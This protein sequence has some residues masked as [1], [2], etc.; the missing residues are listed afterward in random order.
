MIAAV[1]EGVQ[2][3]VVAPGRD[4][5]DEQRVVH[6][7]RRMAV[8][9]FSRCQWKPGARRAAAEIS[10]KIATNLR[11]AG[12]SSG[13]RI[14]DTVAW[15]GTCPARSASIGASCISRALV[16]MRSPQTV[17]VVTHTLSRPLRGADV[18]S[19]HQPPDERHA[20][21]TRIYDEHAVRVFAYAR[22]HAGPD[23]ARDVVSDV[24]LVAWRRLDAVPAEPLPW[25]LVVAR[26]TIANLRRARRRHA[27]ADGDVIDTLDRLASSHG[28]DETV[29]DRAELLAALAALTELEREALLLVAW[30]GLSNREA[31]TVAGCSARAFEVRLSRARARLERELDAPATISFER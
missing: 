30:D 24:F 31:A 9:R 29:V 1:H 10:A 4:A 14:R 12:S 28:A 17:R 6:T 25:L 19:R 5:G 7:H 11:M 16:R 22:R 3:L 20:R 26:N 18:P 27:V 8:P 15:A 21:L 2:G 13:A 23:D